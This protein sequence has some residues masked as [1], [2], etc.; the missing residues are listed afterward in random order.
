M[1]E[2]H[3]TGG[4]DY[5]F[6]PFRVR[7]VTCIGPRKS[8]Y[9]FHLIIDDGARFP[10]ILLR[11]YRN[12]MFVLLS[13]KPLAKAIVIILLIGII[14]VLANLPLPSIRLAHG[15]SRNLSL[16][17]FIAAWNSSTTPNPT[18][19]VIQGDLITL[20]PKPGDGV[21]HQWFLD[22]NNNGVADCSPGPDICS[23]T[24]SSSSPP[25]V[26]F[27]AGF[28]PAAYTLTYY[29]SVHPGT[30]HGHF[31]AMLLTVGGD[32]YAD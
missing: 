25:P 1:R 9:R 21:S 15:I 4:N 18:I 29:C 24:F 12:R 11:C 20:S 8:D 28:G 7:F 16:L 5:R 14:P 26:I 6:H 3:D 19:T 31:T 10:I 22:V 17:G 27:T 13:F 23:A 30:M 2:G 32:R